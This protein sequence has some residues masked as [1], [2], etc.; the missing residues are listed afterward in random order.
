MN[1]VVTN[2]AVAAI[3]PLRQ[4]SVMY[5]HRCIQYCDT[6]CNFIFILNCILFFVAI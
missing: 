1:A 3:L 4:F 2:I 6:V 5:W